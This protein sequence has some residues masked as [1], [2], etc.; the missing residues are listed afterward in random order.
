MSDTSTLGELLDRHAL[1]LGLSG[2]AQTL[3]RDAVF[4]IGAPGTYAP[5]L[6]GHMNL[7]RPNQLQVL[8]DAEFTYLDAQT[9]E[10]AQRIIAALL[11]HRPAA[12][13]VAGNLDV[14]DLLL[15]GCQDAGVSLMRAAMSSEQVVQELSYYLSRSATRRSSIH[16]VLIEIMG[17][18]VLLTGKAGVGKSELALELLTRG[19]RLIADD[20]PE[21]TRVAPDTVEG[22]CPPALRDF[23]EVRGL[24]I[25]NVRA[26]F[27]DSAVKPRRALRL[28]IKLVVLD[29][30]GYSAEQRL[31]GIRGT[32]EVLG[33]PIP[34]VSL[35]IALGHNMAVLVECTVRNFILSMKG[36][37]AAEDFAN[38]QA[39]IMRG[40][41]IAEG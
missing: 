4:D 19:H 15:V 13:I 11:G 16:G 38:R 5:A 20:A 27:G 17:V 9:V 22:S 34:E 31:Q 3:K 36:Y 21:F 32:R 26:L 28:V 2:V 37:D 39:A 10:V 18:G 12:L 33:I 8:G 25:I 1:R 30:G 41:I 14:P 35:P 6:I 24:G 29:E 40:E 7:I 23:M